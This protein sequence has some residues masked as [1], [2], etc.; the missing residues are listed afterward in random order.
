MDESPTEEVSQEAQAA[1]LDILNESIVDDLREVFGDLAAKAVLMHTKG[2]TAGD[3]I[4]EFSRRLRVLFGLGAETL[5]R[6]IVQ[7]LYRRIDLRPKDDAVFNFERKISEA[8]KMYVARRLE[9]S[10]K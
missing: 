2:S 5:E 3:D 4:A 9:Q 8:K 1:F 7:E 6:N 10:K